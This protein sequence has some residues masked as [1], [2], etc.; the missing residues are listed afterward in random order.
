MSIWLRFLPY[1]AAVLL[2]LGALYGAYRHGVSVTDATWQA[3]WAERDTRDATAKADNESAQRVIEQT[4]QLSMNK[5]IQDGQRT[6]DQAT[7]DA[8]NARAAADSLRGEADKLAAR[9]AA[10]QAG[11]HSCTAATSAAATRAIMVFADV[12]K[13][14]DERAGDLAGYAQDS[15]ARGVTCQQA[16]GALSSD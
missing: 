10:S 7:A 1:I 8:A 3:Q 6:L 4:R 11:G 2:A 16:Y 5:A 15:H 12:L 13:R 14:A 9:L